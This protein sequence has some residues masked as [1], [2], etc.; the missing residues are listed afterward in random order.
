M[1]GKRLLWLTFSACRTII[2]QLLSNNITKSGKIS[3]LWSDLIRIMWLIR[4]CHFGRCVKRH[5][6]IIILIFAFPGHWLVIIPVIAHQTAL[7]LW[8]LLWIV[9]YLCWQSS[10]VWDVHFLTSITVCSVAARILTANSQPAIMPSAVTNAVNLWIHP[11]ALVLRIIPALQWTK[12]RWSLLLSIRIS[13]LRLQSWWFFANTGCA[14]FTWQLHLHSWS[15][16]THNISKWNTILYQHEI[17]LILLIR[18]MLLQGFYRGSVNSS[19]TIFFSLGL[20]AHCW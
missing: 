6:S 8:V 11:F 20:C 5:T 9:D 7:D 18:I 3:V 17:L 13:R 16:F 10:L 1:S 14:V 15:T 19:W 4:T 12:S 2:R